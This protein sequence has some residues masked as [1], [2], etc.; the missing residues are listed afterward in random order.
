MAKSI[1]RVFAVTVLALFLSGCFSNQKKQLATCVLDAQKLYPDSDKAP[2]GQSSKY[3][4]TC[5]NAA[6]YE[7]S[8]HHKKC[9]AGLRASEN[10]YCYIPVGRFERWIYEMEM[11]NE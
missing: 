6:G 5:M 1:W 4:E 7:W 3:V 8:M 11:A 2:V 10:P 9:F